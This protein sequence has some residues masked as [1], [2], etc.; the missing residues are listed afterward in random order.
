MNIC[1]TSDKGN[2]LIPGFLHQWEKY[3]EESVKIVGFTRP[4]CDCDFLSLGDFKDYPVN[5]WSNAL[6]NLLNVLNDDF[7]E[8]YLEDYWLM[9]PVNVEAIAVARWVMSRTQ[10][11]GCFDL[12]C[13]REYARENYRDGGSIGTV[14]L[15]ES[16]RGI[17]YNFSY[18]ASIWRREALL[19]LVEP[20]ETP[21]ES[22]L[23]GD[24]RMQDS[25]WRVFGTRQWPVKYMIVVNK[26]QF[27]KEGQWMRPARTLSEE[28]WKGL[29]KLGY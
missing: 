21:W 17:P 23:N 5:R 25:R 14:D 28:N 15:L 16:A 20:D 4:D 13:D 3:N 8:L 9:R 6:I 12:T 22:E 10:D 2:W 27:D 11:I 7:I 29:A 19:E 1:L 24:H 18:Q 26:G